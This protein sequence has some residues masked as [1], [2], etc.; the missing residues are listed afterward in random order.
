MTD[1]TT[2][3]SQYGKRGERKKGASVP[4]MRHENGKP[5]NQ[6]SC[7]LD[8][9]CGGHYD[10]AGR[11]KYD[12]GVSEWDEWNRARCERCDTTMATLLREASA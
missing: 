12:I 9:R 2:Y 10:K 8:L 6:T 5:T 4:A 11:F 3:R 1:E 7:G